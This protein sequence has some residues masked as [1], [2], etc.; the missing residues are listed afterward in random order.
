MRSPSVGRTL[1]RWM[2]PTT[3]RWLAC[4]SGSA[5][6]SRTAELVSAG[7]PRAASVSPARSPHSDYSREANGRG[8]AH[9]EEN[10]SRDE[11]G[12]LVPARASRSGRAARHA[13]EFARM[14]PATWRGLLVASLL[15]PAVV[16]SARPA[17][18]QAEIELLSATF[19]PKQWQQTLSDGSQTFVGC[20]QTYAARRC[21]DLLTDREFTD[22]GVEYE[23]RNFNYRVDVDTAQTVVDRVFT[24]VFRPTL[25]IILQATTLHVGDST[26]AFAAA[27]GINEGTSSPNRTWDAGSGVLTADTPVSIRLTRPNVAP[28]AVDGEV[29]TFLNEAY[30]FDGVGLP[31]L[32]RGRGARPE[33]SEREDRGAPRLG[34]ADAR[35]RGGGGRPV[36]GEKG[37]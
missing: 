26:F 11:G 17:S 31:V 13:A 33:P 6:C 12:G 27:R 3:T 15:V 32:G 29:G 24:I 30:T 18:A 5:W 20:Q 37:H 36:G 2:P 21:S 10:A 7:A 22:E 23:V 1:G 16:A 34:H 28:T 9:G 35:R 8:H 4:S 25:S 19:T 14:A